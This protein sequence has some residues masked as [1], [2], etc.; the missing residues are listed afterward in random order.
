MKLTMRPSV[1][2][3]LEIIK[4]FR[5]SN[6]VLFFLFLTFFLP[7]SGT[8]NSV[9]RMSGLLES[10]FFSAYFASVC[11]GA[12]LL[13][14]LF[15]VNSAG[16]E[17]SEGSFRRA[18]AMG[19]TKTDFYLGKLQAI[20]FFGI[21]ILFF[22]LLMYIV[23][24]LT[25]FNLAFSFDL[26][27]IPFFSLAYKFFA[28]FYAGVLGLTFIIMFR[29]T[30]FGLVFFP[31]LMFTEITLHIFARLENQ[32]NSFVNYMP[33]TV[34]WH[35]FNTNDFDAKAFSMVA[36]YTIFLIGLSYWR[37]NTQELRPE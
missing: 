37:L 11:A 20:S 9:A 18:L 12:L 4:L 28:L 35:L 29:N 16:K 7:Q 19:Y 33:G 8:I 2:A 21:L 5:M 6:F 25:E 30:A 27:T 32:I 3:R 14:T 34:G 23:F 15:G 1:L 10:D 13:M 36:F 26:S 17:F 31:V 22:T 24:G